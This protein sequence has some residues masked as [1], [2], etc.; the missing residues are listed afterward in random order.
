MADTILFNSIWDF[1]NISNNS[2][3]I[4][5]LK[6]LKKNVL[7]QNKTLY[8]ETLAKYYTL[9]PYLQTKMS[10]KDAENVFKYISVLVRLAS[11]GNRENAIIYYNS[12][13]DY[14]INYICGI[15][16]NSKQKILD[17]IKLKERQIKNKSKV[18]Y[19]KRNAA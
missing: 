19:L 16:P 10:K 11:S 7:E 3:Y 15:Y 13:L 18:K 1:L 2:A 14:I 6:Q 5:T 17:T 8:A 12:M 4:E 9:F